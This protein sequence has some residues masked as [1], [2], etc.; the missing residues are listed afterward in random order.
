MTECENVERVRKHKDDKV[1]ARKRVSAMRELQAAIE[2][3]RRSADALC[4]ERFDAA[5]AWVDGSDHPRGEV[6][7]VGERGFFW[8]HTDI[9]IPTFVSWIDCWVEACLD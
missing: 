5:K 6:T 7:Q 3:L 8:R 4:K 9:I 2:K 1:F